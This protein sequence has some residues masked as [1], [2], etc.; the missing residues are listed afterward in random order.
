M[1]P[2]EGHSRSSLGLPSPYKQTYKQ[3]N[4]PFIVLQ[5]LFSQ[6]TTDTFTREG[7]DPVPLRRRHPPQPLHVDI[8][9]IYSRTETVEVLL[10]MLITQKLYNIVAKF[11]NKYKN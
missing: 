11:Y 5:I 10:E 1:G 6:R 2:I 4:N 3:P 7:R 8:Y 9:L